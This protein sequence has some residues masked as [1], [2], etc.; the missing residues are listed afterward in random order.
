MKFV[1]AKVTTSGNS[2]KTALPITT[3]T[4]TIVNEVNIEATTAILDIQSPSSVPCSYPYIF[5]AIV[6]EGIFISPT[7][8]E[9]QPT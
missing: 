8:P 2:G 7:E 3:K 4:V 5:C 9:I 6:I 1:S